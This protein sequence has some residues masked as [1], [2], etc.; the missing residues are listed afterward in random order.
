MS[1]QLPSTQMETA[2]TEAAYQLR[3]YENGDPDLHQAKLDLAELGAAWIDQLKR[4]Y[5]DKDNATT[6]E[7]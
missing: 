2:F 7:E 5:E 4:E 3:F 6:E 1:K